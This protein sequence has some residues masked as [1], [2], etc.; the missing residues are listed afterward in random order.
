MRASSAPARITFP[1]DTCCFER[2]VERGCTVS[3]ARLIGAIRIVAAAVV[4]AAFVFASA[5]TA[6]AHTALDASSP[7]DGSN[8]DASPSQLVLHFASPILSVGDR[9]V[10]QGPDGQEYQ[11][12]KSQIVDSTVTQP[13]RPLGPTGVYQVAIRVVADDG[14]PNDFEM[15]FTLTKPGP[16]AGGANAV[17]VP[18]APLAQ[19]G[20]TANNAPSWAPWI[21][22]A[23]VLIFASGAVLLGRR[24]THDLG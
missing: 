20:S 1:T 12:G 10:V 22:A 23:A 11:T 7:Q 2:Q 8:I 18:P 14:H 15:R 13:L 21:P 3:S 19:V 5:P 4:S 6:S 9:I 16:A 17:V 24:A